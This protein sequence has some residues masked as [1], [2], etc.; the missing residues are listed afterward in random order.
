M[1]SHEEIRQPLRRHDKAPFPAECQ[2]DEECRDRGED[3]PFPIAP[4]P[5]PWPRVFPSL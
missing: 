5:V 3:L 4:P 2:R 1:K